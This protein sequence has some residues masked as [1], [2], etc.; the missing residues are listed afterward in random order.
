MDVKERIKGFISAEL[1]HKDAEVTI[2]DEE[3]LLERGILDSLGLL[4]L[5][6]FL[7]NEY[8]F[9][10]QDEEVIPENFESINAIATFVKRHKN[11]R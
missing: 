8:Q 7:E 9:A 4:R 5:L 2:V 11:G 6:G 1:M 10:I 3:S